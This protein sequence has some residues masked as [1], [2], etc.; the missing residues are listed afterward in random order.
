MSFNVGMC[1]QTLVY[2]YYNLSL[3]NIKYQ[4]LIH[5]TTNHIKNHAIFLKAYFKMIYTA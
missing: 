1:R 4:T 5:I 2:L 3:S